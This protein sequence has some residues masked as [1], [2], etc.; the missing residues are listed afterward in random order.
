MEYYIDMHCHCLPGI[1]DGAK[2]KEE[3]L[4]MLKQAYADGIRGIIAT[5]HYHYRRGNASKEV[6]LAKVAEMQE[7]VKESCPELQIYPGN[8]L[9][10][11]SHLVEKMEEESVCTMAGSRYVLIE[12]SPETEYAE[13]RNALLEIQTLGVWPIL[14]HIE[15]YFCLV[16]KPVLALELADMGVYL[17]VN[18]DGVLGKYGRKEKGLI[19]KMFKAGRISFVATDAHDTELRKQKLSECAEYVKK[20]YGEEIMKEC[21]FDNP[22]AVIK[23][24]II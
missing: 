20:K 11:N 14:A 7:A 1:D 8:E 5:P 23:N 9:G 16:S 13:I 15:R 6:V 4:E 2:N 19:K 10:Y 12:F 21:F 18:A 24:I 22:Q 17:Q 3:S